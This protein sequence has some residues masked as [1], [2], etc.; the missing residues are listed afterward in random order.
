M[1]NFY[2]REELESLGF[3]RLGEDVLISK[4]ASIF[5]PENIEIGNHVRIDDFCLLSGNIKLGNYIHIAAYSA[6]FGGKGTIIM[7]DFSGLAFRCSIVAETDDYSGMYLT[8]PEIDIQYRKITT[9]TVHIGKHVVLG[10]GSV[11]LPGVDIGEG[12]SFG[13]MALVNKNT[14]PWGVYVGAPCKR[15]KE[16]SK[17]MLNLEKEFLASEGNKNE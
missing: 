11:V 6:F 17:E 4:R 5:R 8:N 7:D 14:E 9:S 15:L 13:S 12:C 10:T 2:S 16:R 3:K 1:Y